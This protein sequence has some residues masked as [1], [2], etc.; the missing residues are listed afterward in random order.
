MTYQK[1]FVLSLW[2]CSI[3]ALGAGN[4]HIERW[5]LPIFACCIG[6]ATYR[7][8]I[9]IPKEHT[10][11]LLLFGVWWLALLIPIPNTLLPL[12]QNT[13]GEYR[14]LILTYL[15]LDSTIAV[16]P[17][18]HLFNG[19][20]ILSLYGLFLYLRSRQTAWE[21]AVL[22]V[23]LVFASVGTIQHLTGIDKIYGFIDVPSELRS[24]FFAS[25][26][27]GNHAAY[28]MVCG[29]FLSKHVLNGIRNVGAT[30]VF[31]W[32]ILICESRGAIG[33]GG[34]ALLWLYLPKYRL[35]T[36][37]SSALGIAGLLLSQD[38]D[39]LSH[40]RWT[41]WMDSISL[42][43]WSWLLGLG[44]GS[45]G[46]V[47]PMIKT[48]PE[49]I[50]SSHLHMEYLEW[51]FQTGL[52]G[53]ILLVSFFKELLKHS[54]KMILNNPWWLVTFTILLASCVDF[55][56][57]LNAIAIFFVIG[58]SQIFSCKE[59]PQPSSYQIP[60]ISILGFCIALL[61]LLLP[62]SSP[63]YNP[64]PTKDSQLA[65]SHLHPTFLEQHIWSIAKDIPTDPNDSLRFSNELTTDSLETIQRLHPIIIQ[66]AEYFS[67]NIEAQRLL[68][69]WYRRLGNY[70]ESCR[71]WQQVWSLETMVLADKR[72]WMAEGLACDPNL[73]VVL[74]TI[75]DDV[76]LLLEASR[77]LDKQ[78]QREASRF[79]LERAYEIEEPPYRSGLLL[80]KWLIGEKNW[81][82]AWKT[83]RQITLSSDSTL[84]ERC[85]YLKNEAELGLHF[86]LNNTSRTHL[87][88]L[89][90]C[91][92]RAYWRQRYWI[93]GLK[94]SSS[95]MVN[96]VEEHLNK[97][98]EKI[99]QFWKYLVHA[100]T[101]LNNQ[102]SACQWIEHA[103]H[104]DLSPSQIDVQNCSQGNFPTPQW[105]WKLMTSAEV[106]TLVE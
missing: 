104:N 44:F 52:L 25:F 105:S 91:G 6:I 1:L 66:H 40:G 2:C 18:L 101:K 24:P 13:L 38:L 21:T 90:L 103:F 54:S 71:I 87:D 20:A 26:I 15:D 29:L 102:V 10:P 51:W 76:E 60:A 53:L 83:H 100:H 27:N 31:I 81:S 7:Q 39:M 93:S 92:E 45:F 68:A 97:N 37:T 70:G 11:W 94:E 46:S 35:W 49:Y 41:M 63:V 73:W 28:L 55:P 9:S 42:L 8:K 58:L 23:L 95:S 43:D 5:W 74:T 3:L 14:V 80:T 30:C 96:I 62:L 84:P 85:S 82:R 72:A 77:L 50:Q 64:S 79:C 17:A 32:G 19:G 16:H 47:Y 78:S 99:T 98:P 86:H 33:L 89:E 36:I 48:S 75:P 61:S 106:D 34:L 65:A 59:L 22:K 12:L 56:L 4:P 57:Q 69:R 88:L 67:S